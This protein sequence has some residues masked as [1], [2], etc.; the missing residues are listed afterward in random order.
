MSCWDGCRVEVHENYTLSVPAKLNLTTPEF[1]KST[2]RCL[3][4]AKGVASSI[5][6]PQVPYASSIKAF[7]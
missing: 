2:F 5:V 1:L 3:R 4:E 6:N 7:I